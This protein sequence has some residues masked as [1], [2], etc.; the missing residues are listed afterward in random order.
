MPTLYSMVTETRNRNRI[1]ETCE[2][3]IW[4]RLGITSTI[5]YRFSPNFARGSGMSSHRTPICDTDRKQVANFR[6][7]RILIS[8]VFRLW[9]AHLSTAQHQIPCTDKI[10]QCRLCIQ[11]WLKPE[12]E[13]ATCGSGKRTRHT[14]KN[15][16]S[17][18]FLSR[19]HAS[20]ETNEIICIS[21]SCELHWRAPNWKRHPCSSIAATCKIILENDVGLIDS[22]NI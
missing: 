18:T 11:W 7:V 5:L 8:A 19:L 13:I 14:V 4:F 21:T 9:W 17:N 22:T 20:S 16:A 12:I 15:H 1:L 6:G 3:R 10:R 2:F